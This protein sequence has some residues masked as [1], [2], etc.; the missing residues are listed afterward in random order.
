[1]KRI[2][3]ELEKELKSNEPSTIDRKRNILSKAFQEA[4]Y[5]DDTNSGFFTHIQKLTELIFRQYESNTHLNKY[6]IEANAHQKTKRSYK[7]LL[8]RFD[9]TNRKNTKLEEENQKLQDKYHKLYKD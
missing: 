5:S 3:L 4:S 6:E 8:Q 2:E 1:M 9:D 7:D